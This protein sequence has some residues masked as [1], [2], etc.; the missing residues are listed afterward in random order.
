MIRN[1]FIYREIKY[2]GENDFLFNNIITANKIEI[3]AYR[4][5]YTFK[6]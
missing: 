5:Y 4:I 1:T 2:Y 3:Y 6:Y